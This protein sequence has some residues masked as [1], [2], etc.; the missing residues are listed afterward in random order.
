MGHQYP[1]PQHEVGLLKCSPASQD[2]NIAEPPLS[3]TTMPCLTPLN[4]PLSSAPQMPPLMG[5]T[6][7]QQ[8][9]Q[10]SGTPLMH[11]PMPLTMKKTTSKT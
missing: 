9:P 7:L 2:F 1:C 6:H 3:S 8:P 5:A 4:E 10:S 11:S